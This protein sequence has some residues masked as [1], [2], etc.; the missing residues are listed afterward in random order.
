MGIP[1]LVGTPYREG[2]CPAALWSGM[3]FV[4]SAPYESNKAKV[5]GVQNAAVNSA[6]KVNWSLDECLWEAVGLPVEGQVGDLL[7]ALRDTE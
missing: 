5:S 7:L 2:P 4:M 1:L 3:A 6:S